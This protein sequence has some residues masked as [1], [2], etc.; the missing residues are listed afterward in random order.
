MNYTVINHPL[1]QHKITLLRDKDLPT[2]AFREITNELTMLLTYE[3][4]RDLHLEPV[5]TVTPMSKTT[6]QLIKDDILIVPILRAGL[7]MENGVQTLIPQAKIAHIG[8]YRDPDTHLPSIYYEKYPNNTEK[9]TAYIVDPLLATGGSIIAAIDALK[10]QGVKTIK[11]LSVIG[12]S[13]GL[14]NIYKKHPDVKVYLGSLDS[15]LNEN[16]YIIP[17]LGDAGDRL[18]GTK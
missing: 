7:G 9:H 18:F 10:N 12:V 13:E 3:I 16:A 2:K 1:I 14:Q 8:M 17:G 6:G 4:S 11:V 15:H 5:D